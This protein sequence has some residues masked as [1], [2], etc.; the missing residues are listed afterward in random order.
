[1]KKAKVLFQIVSISF[2]VLFFQACSIKIKMPV[3]ETTPSTNSFNDTVDSSKA[4]KLKF[5]STLSDDYKVSVGT[6]TDTFKVKHKDKDIDAQTFIKEGLQ[7]E[8]SSRKLPI[9]FSLDS[10]DELTLEHFNILSRRTSAY[11]PMVTLSTLKIKVNYK[12]ETKT[13]ASFIKRGKVP[14]WSMSELYEP[15]Y[16]EPTSLLIREVVAKI[17]KEYFNY[18]L[19][20]TKVYEIISKIEKDLAENKKLIYLDVYE[21]AFSNNQI[22]LNFLEKLTAN[23]DEYVRLSAISGLGILGSEEQLD[24]LINL[25]QNSKLWQDRAMALKSIGDIGTTK[26]LEFLRT[27]K[28]LFSLHDSLEANWNKIIFNLYLQ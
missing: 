9:E 6:Q 19:S 21:L 15:C 11:S 27:E 26:A 1:M 4:I 24:L 2:I 18:K 28:N 23:I 10:S 22:A 12:G 17:N 25:Y 13:F 5:K 7:K 20:D 14:L 3:S 16:N 8:F